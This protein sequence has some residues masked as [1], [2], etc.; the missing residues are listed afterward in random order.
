MT[1]LQQL[2]ALADLPLEKR[3]VWRIASSLKWGF[4]D[5]EDM[6]VVADKKTL[7]E[8]DFARVRELLK[9]R[10]I[11]FCMFLEALF[12]TDFVASGKGRLGVRIVATHVTMQE[13]IDHQ[14]GGYTDRPIFDKTG[15][16]APFDFTL[17]FAVENPTSGQEVGPNDPPALVTA[18]QEQLGLKLE[19]STAPFDTVV[20][21]HAAKPAGN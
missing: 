3:Y 4:A 8:E 6:N 18:V 12:G 17:E 19:A 14:L 11:Q 16:T 15:L 13:L 20:I 5:F 21:D 2:K 9:L 10:P 1:R 7:T